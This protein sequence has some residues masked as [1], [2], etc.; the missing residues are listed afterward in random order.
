MGG[1][2]SNRGPKR[3]KREH[4]LEAASIGHYV[5]GADV[6]GAFH[7]GVCG[8]W[9]GVRRELIVGVEQRGDGLLLPRRPQWGGGNGLGLWEVRVHNQQQVAGRAA[10]PLV[11]DERPNPKSRPV[12]VEA[13]GAVNGAGLCAAR[14]PRHRDHTCVWQCKA[15]VGGLPRGGPRRQGHGLKGGEGGD[16]VVRGGATAGRACGGAG[17]GATRGGP[18]KQGGRTSSIAT[19]SI[20]WGNDIR[21]GPGGEGARVEGSHLR[22]A[23]GG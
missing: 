4:G 8:G 18:P 11:N 13:S 1:L 9:L 3:G 19:H 10:A 6:G 7:T 22:A 23:R 14:A 21:G 15:C 17:L 5:V 20:T 16:T 12:D 2:A